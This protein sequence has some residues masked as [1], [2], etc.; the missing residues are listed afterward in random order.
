MPYKAKF[1]NRMTTGNEVRY[2]EATSEITALGGTAGTGTAK[3]VD[4]G[5]SLAVAD[6]ASGTN[7]EVINTGTEAIA[8]GEKFYAVRVKTQW[9]VVQGG[10]GGV[11][12]GMYVIVAAS[13]ISAATW[14]TAGTGTGNIYELIGSSWSDTSGGTTVDV[15]NPW[16]EAITSGSRLI[17]TKIDGNYI[18]VQASCEPETP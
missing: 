12:S 13:A 6:A 16:E 14:P 17:C 4:V 10:G 7:V 9:H 2:M 5:G 11:E 8:S 3:I 15:K 1:N 18:I